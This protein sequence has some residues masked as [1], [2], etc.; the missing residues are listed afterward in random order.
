VPG[1]HREGHNI[2]TTVG[3]NW[4]SKLLAWKTV[5]STDIPYTNRRVR[6]M[7]LGSGTQL[8]VSTVTKLVQPQLATAT[9]YLRPIQIVEFTTTSV[10]FTKEFGTSE[11]TGTGAPVGVTEAGLFA[12]V[13]PATAGGFEDVSYDPI[14][15]PASTVLN[16]AIGTN[17]PIAYKA[18]EVLT[19]TSDFS[20]EVRWE[21]R[22]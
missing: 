2:L 4:L 8:E 22:F 14:G 5:A 11:I 9:D 10:L 12:D 17:P 6:W 15:N 19:K 3:K 21:L 13:S 20:L 16:P 7:A 1:S 18:F